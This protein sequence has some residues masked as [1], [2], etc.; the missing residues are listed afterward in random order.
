FVDTSMW[1]PPD[2]GAL[3][4]RV[5]PEQILYASDVPYGHQLTSQYLALAVLRRVGFDEDQLRGVMGE[6]AL[7]LAEGRLPERISSPRGSPRVE[8]E[9]DRVRICTYLSAVTPLLWSG[10]ADVI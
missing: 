9:H 6:T 8:E 4:A 7:A 1:S 2:L 3:A 10:G 5:G